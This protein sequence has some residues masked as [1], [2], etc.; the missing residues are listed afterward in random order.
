MRSHFVSWL[1][2]EL[3]SVLKSPFSL[4]L[5]TYSIRNRI[6]AIGNSA[7]PS[8]PKIKQKWKDEQF[9]S[10]GERVNDHFR[11]AF[12]VPTTICTSGT[13]T[14]WK[15][16]PEVRS[17]PS[18]Y[19]AL[20]TTLCRTPAATRVGVDLGGSPTRLE[21]AAD[22]H[23]SSPESIFDVSPTIDCALLSPDPAIHD[24]EDSPEPQL[25]VARTQSTVAQAAACDALLVTEPDKKW[26]KQ[27]VREWRHLQKRVK[28]SKNCSGDGRCG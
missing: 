24:E 18:P 1:V 19:A 2:S 20:T 12:E 22:G 28:V 5:L 8:F 7:R 26:G 27:E 6:R 3:G 23:V 13:A 10:A 9:I 14:D 25:H 16:R 21:A 15:P 17:R 11:H 4:L